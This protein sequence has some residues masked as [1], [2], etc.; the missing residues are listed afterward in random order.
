MVCS[1][2]PVFEEV[3][4][5]TLSS[6]PCP[7]PPDFPLQPQVVAADSK[8]NLVEGVEGPLGL[9]EDHDAVTPHVVR[10]RPASEMKV[11]AV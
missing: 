2:V 6:F 3:L 1:K 8:E 10:G 7:P 4:I 11:T 9:S 5:F